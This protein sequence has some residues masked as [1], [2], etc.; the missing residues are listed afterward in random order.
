M[1]CRNSWQSPLGEIILEADEKG[2][3]GLWF[4]EGHHGANPDPDAVVLDNPA[5]D[6]AKRWLEDY[7]AGRD[8]GF[9]PPLHLMGTDFRTRVWAA[10]M[11]IPFGRT[12]TYGQ[13][14][15]RV[16]ASARAVGG[17]VGS[18][19]VSL[20]V[21]CHRVVGANGSLTGYAGGLW[22]KEALLR[23]EGSLPEGSEAAQPSPKEKP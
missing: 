18:N 13:I 20:I 15:A 17:A 3:N 5:I 8:P 12:A 19:P 14:A 10:L 11:E 1:K 4:A 21:P 22:R 7:F 16:G 2:L 9:T 6:E 23:L